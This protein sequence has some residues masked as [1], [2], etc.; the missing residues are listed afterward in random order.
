MKS[1]D[2]LKRTA[3]KLLRQPPHWRTPDFGP[4]FK[5][6]MIST[7]RP[8]QGQPVTTTHNEVPPV[9]SEVAG[10][11]PAVAPELSAILDA[12]SDAAR[13]DAWAGFVREYSDQILQVAR[14]LGGDHDLIMDRYAFALERLRE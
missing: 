14:S 2:S 4:S 6:G 1:S 7:P 13:E 11:R 5:A 9:I 10:M 8:L 12:A 3:G